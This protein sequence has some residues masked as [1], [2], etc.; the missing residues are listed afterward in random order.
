MP[1]LPEVETIKNDLKKKVVGKKIIDFELLSPN[2]LKGKSLI[3][4]KKKV[5]G[6]KILDVKRRAKLII[7]R[8]EN[9][10]YIIFH[11]MMTGHL[12]VNSDYLNIDK[13]GTWKEKTGALADPFNQY[14]RA[15]FIL[16]P[17]SLIAFSDLRKFGYIKLL[18]ESEMKII[19][20]K[21][22]PE[23]LSRNFDKNY[24]A[25]LFSEKKIA[26]KKVLMEQAN[27]AGIG[28]IYADEILFLSKI[29]PQKITQ[30]IT[31]KEI[32]K[33]IVNTKKIL[34]KAIILRGTSTSDFRDTR[35]EKGKYGSQL[36]VYRR[37]DLPCKICNTKIKRIVVGGRGTH[38]CPNCQEKND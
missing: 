35:G 30:K 14:I 36:F 11:M 15:F 25:N 38:F 3:D 37:T 22:G 18:K 8:L 1:E 6:T 32:E 17:K 16:K 9:G 31:A 5:V 10:Y 21:Y 20:N 19:E 34:K 12:L 26:I 29:H 28:N 2:T 23:P 7:V 13:K 33:I 4:F 27:I 24:L